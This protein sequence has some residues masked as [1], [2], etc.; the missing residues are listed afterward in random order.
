MFYKN[1]DALKNY[2]SWCHQ[3]KGIEE[4]VACSVGKSC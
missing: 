1:K 4:V 3:G 2:P